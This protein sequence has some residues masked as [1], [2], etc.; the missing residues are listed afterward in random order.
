MEGILEWRA[1]PIVHCRG[2]KL[3]GKRIRG[4]DVNMLTLF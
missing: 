4:E 1:E 2:S 3:P